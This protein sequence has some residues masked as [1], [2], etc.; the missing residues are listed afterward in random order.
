MYSMPWAWRKASRSSIRC[1]PAPLK[2]AQQKIE[3]N[4]IGIR[5]NLL[6]FDQVMNE[7]REIVYEE[8]RKVLDGENIGIPSST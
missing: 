5:K 2:K 7:Q 3:S 1:F 8:R 6:E 4:N